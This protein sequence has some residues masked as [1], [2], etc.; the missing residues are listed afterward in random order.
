[1]SDEED[2]LEVVSQSFE[3][4]FGKFSCTGIFLQVDQEGQQ[5]KKYI[6][7]S[8]YRGGFDYFIDNLIC[9]T[10]ARMH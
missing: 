5:V 4:G 7:F 8:A 3:K 6:K 10:S 9:V 1:M 2:G